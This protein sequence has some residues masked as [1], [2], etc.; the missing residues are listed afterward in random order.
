MT[1][2]NLAVAAICWTL[3]CSGKSTNAGAG[4]SGG[5]GVAGS[6]GA[7]AGN[8]VA[9]ATGGVGFAGAPAGDG[10]S[11][12]ASATAGASACGAPVASAP[13]ISLAD[14]ESGAIPS[15]DTG[16]RGFRASDVA[17]GTII[18]PGADG[19][20]KA[21]QFSFAT[22]NSLFYQSAARPTYLGGS[23]TYDADL[24]N[25]LQFYLRIPAGSTLLAASGGLTFSIYTYHWK[26]GDPWVGGN[27]GASLTDSQMHG[28][29][30][31]RFDPSAAGKWIRVVM[32]AS[33]FDHS[34][35]NYHF[36]AA[37][38]VVEDL[39]FFGA[40]RQFQPVL[41][42]DTTAMPAPTFDLDELG[43]VTLPPTA[44]VCP[45]AYV[46]SV[47]AAA[48]DVIEPVV[49][50][51][52]TATARTYHAFLSSVIGLDRQTIEVATHDADDV[53]AVDNL[54]AAVGSDGSLGAARLFADDGTGKPTGPDLIAAGGAG[55]A[56]PA[57]GSFRAVVVH[58]VTAAMLGPAQTVMNAGHSYAV[59]RD[60]LTTSLIVWDPSA[61]RV[62]DAAVVF[63]GSNADSSH[64][65]PP[66]FPA[67]VDPPTGWRSADVPPDQVGGYFVSVLRLTP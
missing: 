46:A 32:S 9:G 22:D 21:A 23:A 48:G 50:T 64:P 65:A 11:A 28:Y 44:A 16:P 13:P 33:A 67:Y 26:P 45:R 63:T 24:A 17:R 30:P 49:I 59:R 37:Q 25:A 3:A 41:L 31:M 15:S 56:I 34:R 66:G 4:G 47:P 39:T 29:G 18:A 38:A 51:N 62:G 2:R 35:G 14:F 55:I 54:Q 58:H 5:A 60:T 7:A 52:P 61:A 1:A 20:A 12:G 27:A 19:T 36:Y 6:A 8:G 42:A 40:L 53:S 57:G 43:L 10:G